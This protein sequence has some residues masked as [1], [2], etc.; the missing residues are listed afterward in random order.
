MLNSRLTTYFT[1][2]K[3]VYPDRAEKRSEGSAN[4]GFAEV[5]VRAAKPRSVLCAFG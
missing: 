2:V 4:E 3:V 5:I 1:V